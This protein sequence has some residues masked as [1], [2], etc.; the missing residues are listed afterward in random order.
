MDTNA[1]LL[2]QADIAKTITDD[3]DEF[4]RNLAKEGVLTRAAYNQARALLDD[5]FTQFVKNHHHLLANLSGEDAY[6]Q[7]QKYE[8]TDYIVTQFRDLLDKPTKNLATYK[9]DNVRKTQEESVPTEEQASGSADQN[10][11]NETQNQDNE[12]YEEDLLAPNSVT[13]SA[14]VKRQLEDLEKV[15]QNQMQ[16]LKAQIGNEQIP[17]QKKGDL[18][19]DLADLLYDIKEKRED[20]V[21]EFDDDML[22]WIKFRSMYEL[23][24]HN[25]KIPPLQKFAILMKKITGGQGKSILNGFTYNPNNYETAWN[26]IVKHFHHPAMLVRLEMNEFLQMPVMHNAEPNKGQKMRDMFNRSNRFLN[27]LRVIFNDK[28][29]KTENEVLLE[30][31]NAF[32]IYMVESGLNDQMKIAWGNTR[33]DQRKVPDFSEI[34]S[35]LE[36]RAANLEYFSKKNVQLSRTTEVTNKP[37]NPIKPKSTNKT[38]IAAKPNNKGQICPM[39]KGSHQLNSCPKFNK[40]TPKYR[41]DFVITHRL[42]GNCF[43]H[44]YDAMDPCRQKNL[45]NTCGGPHNTLMHR[46]KQYK[47]RKNNAATSEKAKASSS[48]AKALVVHGTNTDVILN[49]T[50]LVTVKDINGHKHTMRALLDSGSDVSFIDQKAASNLHLP[51]KQQ[52]I[53]ITGIGGFKQKFSKTLSLDVYSNQ[54]GNYHLVVE[55]IVL[56]KIGT[57]IDSVPL[58]DKLISKL[59]LADP[60]QGNRKIDLILG[61]PAI[62]KIIQGHTLQLQENVIAMK[63]KLGYVL[64]GSIHQG[65]DFPRNARCNYASEQEWDKKMAAFWEMDEEPETDDDEVCE[66]FYKETLVKLPGRY[67]VGIP[68]RPLKIGDSIKM[69]QARLFQVLKYLEKHPEKAEL[70]RQGMQEMIDSGHMEKVDWVTAKNVLPHSGVY[71]PDHLTT[72]LRIVFDGSARTSNGRSLNDVMMTG[73]KLQSDICVILMRFR[74]YAYVF[75]ADITKM[76]RQIRVRVEDAAYQCVMWKLPGQPIEMFRINVVVFGLASSPFLAIRTL[77]QVA[78]DEG[79]QFPLARQVIL[80]NFYIDDVLASFA[81]VSEAKKAVKE[82]RQALLNRGF[83]L[84]KWVSN[85]NQVLQDI[86]EDSKIQIIAKNIDYDG[87]K[88]LGFHYNF[89]TDSLHFKLQQDMSTN[90]TKR[91]VLSK[92]MGLYDPTGLLQPITFVLKVMMQ[93]IWKSSIGWDDQIPEKIAK[94]WFQFQEELPTISNLK[95]PRCVN[96]NEKAQ[97]IAFSD[98]SDRGY[99]SAIYTRNLD[100]PENPEVRLLLSKSKVGH[101]NKIQS[102][103][104]MELMGAVVMADMLEKVKEAFHLQDNEQIIAFMDSQAV[105]AQLQVSD[106]EVRLKTFVA[107]RVKYVQA[108]MDTS[109]IFYIDTK[110]NPADKLTR[111]LMPNEIIKD[112]LW[113]EGPRILRQP[114]LVCKREDYLL[115]EVKKPKTKVA[116]LAQADEE[117][118]ITQLIEKISSWNRLR[119]IVVLLMRW[120]TKMQGP[121]KADEIQKAEDII[122]K[123]AQRQVFEQEIKQ[124]SKGGQ[125]KNG[126]LSVWKPQVVDG[127]LI[128]GGRLQKSELSAA[129]KH[130]V[131]IPKYCSPLKEKNYDEKAQLAKTLILHAHKETLHGG[132][133]QVSMYLHQKYRIINATSAIRYILKRCVVC[134]RYNNPKTEQLMGELPRTRVNQAHAFENCSVDYFGP[135]S[136]KA[137]FLRNVKAM[138]AWGAVFVCNVTKAVH[139]ELVTELSAECYIAALK[140]FIGRRAVPASIISDN[141]TNF[142]SSEKLLDQDTKKFIQELRD[143]KFQEYIINYCSNLKIDF[144]FI[145]AYCPHVGGLHEAGVKA[146]KRHLM[147][148]A[149]SQLFNYEGMNSL[150][151]QIEAMLNSR[152]LVQTMSDD[153]EAEIITPGHFLTGRPLNS[154]PEPDLTNNNVVSRWREIEK[155]AQRFWKVWSQ[156]YLQDLQ[157]RTKWIAQKEN[158]KLG[159]IVLLKSDMMPKCHW[160]LGKIVKLHPDQSGVVRIVDVERGNKTDTRHIIKLCILPIY[161]FSDP[162]DPE[163]MAPQ[164]DLAQTTQKVPET[165]PKARAEDAKPIKP[166]KRGTRSS[167]RIRNRQNKALMMLM[168]TLAL[169]SITSATL[170]DKKEIASNMGKSTSTVKPVSICQKLLEMKRNQP[171]VKPIL[172]LVNG[173]NTDPP[174]P[175]AEKSDEKSQYTWVDGQWIDLK[176]KEGQDVVKWAWKNET[177]MDLSTFNHSAPITTTE[178][179]DFKKS[180]R[181][182]R[183]RST[184]STTQKTLQLS[185]MNDGRILPGVTKKPE[186]NVTNALFQ[187][188]KPG[189]IQMVSEGS[190]VLVHDKIV[191]QYFG[192][193]KVHLET[194]ANITEDYVT[195]SE[196]EDKMVATC[197]NMYRDVT[198]KFCKGL[199]TRVQQEALRARGLLDVYNTPGQQFRHKRNIDE[200]TSAKDLPKLSRQVRRTKGF[201][202]SII[203]WLFGGDDDFQD[204]REHEIKIDHRI[205][206]I[207]K[208]FNVLRS[209]ELNMLDAVKSME[210]KVRDMDNAGGEYNYEL[211]HQYTHLV[212]YMAIHTLETLERKYKDLEHP[213]L[214]LDETKELETRF[215]NEMPEGATLPAEKFHILLS[216]AERKVM[217]DENSQIIITY[218]I[219]VVYKD[220]YQVLRVL[221]TP[222]WEEGVILKV[223]EAE[224]AINEKTQQY[225]YITPDIEVIEINP[226][227][228]IAKVTRLSTFKAAEKDCIA[229]AILRHQEH[230]N[231]CEAE[232]IKNLSTTFKQLARQRYLFYSNAP[233]PGYIVCGESRLVLESGIGIINLKPG[234]FIEAE[235]EKISTPLDKEVNY[236]APSFYVIPEK[237]LGFEY[238]K[239]PSMQET[240]ISTVVNNIPDAMDETQGDD[241]SFIYMEKHHI[242]YMDYH[243]YV[244]WG[245]I[246]FAFNIWICLMFYKKVHFRHSL[247]PQSLRRRFSRRVVRPPNSFQEI[248][249]SFEEME[250]ALQELQDRSPTNVTS[251]PKP[252]TP[253]QNMATF[254][255]YDHPCTPSKPILP[256][257]KE[258]RV[259]PSGSENWEKAGFTYL[260]TTYINHKGTQ[261]S[262]VS[263]PQEVRISSRPPIHQGSSNSVELQTVNLEDTNKDQP[264]SGFTVTGKPIWPTDRRK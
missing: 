128:V 197:K 9:P 227:V 250:I 39:C 143:D 256:P 29:T 243:L 252:G 148:V 126:V 184:S 166:S 79:K 13:T 63:T 14:H 26:T 81:T 171:Y 57:P 158:V 58:D 225:F 118:R 88:A 215:R 106:P 31:F 113:W 38:F 112:Q 236:Q 179:I 159:Q 164:K 207:V 80:N 18:T 188:E 43:K 157:Q 133:Q 195:I 1:I 175:Q 193:V 142:V 102:T 186:K 121:I 67:E 156:D 214:T 253:K 61:I 69:A 247:V 220:E 91:E 30:S 192:T 119:R 48:Q 168:T 198:Y 246:V 241:N 85:D 233:I 132:V 34:M 76:F 208:S 45:C 135:I 200:Q 229:N 90:K 70:Y 244:I 254:L 152:P 93:D 206:D 51:A 169:I 242:K 78:E 209:S 124:L 74:Q 210:Q 108:R 257:K 5:S 218:N 44:P 222:K 49:P 202:H 205:D 177:W 150:F 194:G 89:Q 73:P 228:S 28:G 20:E 146:A 212:Y 145:P 36:R 59:P 110:E 231:D 117:N 33:K 136:I 170:H 211:I 248:P 24:V 122:I 204:V 3:Y 226:Q 101:L 190:L 127:M 11:N 55:A 187:A 42:C 27:N 259:P 181:R 92:I 130:N 183:T 255:M 12:S 75:S 68:F 178:T 216:L 125:I 176:A 10:V 105:I 249:A 199:V 140:R 87:I 238:P 62:T 97:I 182:R 40:L 221:A 123:T 103:P 65:K 155:Q 258:A 7:E 47:P 56:P 138:K 165:K 50:A 232:P 185:M 4:Q 191:H 149:G 240:E 162:T 84:S 237:D 17:Q 104:R 53:N 153:L 172:D 22:T 99:G 86:P 213:I 23:N 15:L 139:L 147:K 46:D 66:N 94:R 163:D 219:P 134:R 98:G 115:T 114:E 82:L 262:D 261:I 174:N 64:F 111:G 2:E 154:L 196:T 95:I 72:K 96:F 141:G 19:S 203:S 161:S 116:L 264:P 235:K 8:A 54:P 260:P 41:W 189:K 16:A 234:C 201:L 60:K 83:P 180:T 151:I 25:K 129:A 230:P 217:M 100:N 239:L 251:T 21:P 77:N 35:F 144:K 224:I 263:L 107:N 37:S 6:F 160:N 109:K 52:H 131:I 120:K 167:L 223:P 173:K 71:K 32:M 137:S 245:I